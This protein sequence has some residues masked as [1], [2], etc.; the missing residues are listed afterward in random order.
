MGYALTEFSP[1]RR[2]DPRQAFQKVDQPCD[3]ARKGFMWRL[4][5]EAIRDGVKST[6]RFRH[7]H[8]NKRS[9]LSQSRHQRQAPG[10]KGGHATRRAA[11]SNRS[12]P[13]AEA[14]PS[15][16]VPAGMQASYTHEHQA[17]LYPPSPSVSDHD[18]QYECGDS[19]YTG[20]LMGTG[21]DMLGTSPLL[22]PDTGRQP[23]A[24]TPPAAM[25]APGLNHHHFMASPSPSLDEPRTPDSSSVWPD[26]VGVATPYLEDSMFNSDTR[27]QEFLGQ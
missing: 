8:P 20:P 15:R 23:S 19:G 22:A 11:R 26:D 27:L 17:M 16:S 5:D 12:Y 14:P 18:F 1:R 7:K 10:T 2:A 6:T 3:D 13:A 21:F 4:T 9:A 24:L 25:V